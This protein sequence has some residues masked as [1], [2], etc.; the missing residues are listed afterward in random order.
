MYSFKDVCVIYIVLRYSGKIF[1]TFFFFPICCVWVS[2]T[3]KRVKSH[4]MFTVEKLNAR[5]NIYKI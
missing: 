2:C 3:Y 4:D 5:Y 1:I